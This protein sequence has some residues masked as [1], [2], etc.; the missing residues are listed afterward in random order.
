MCGINFV[1][2]QDVGN[3]S[4]CPPQRWALPHHVTSLPGMYEM[5]PKN[6]VLFI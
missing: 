2:L 3:K 5:G 4:D 1:L 6:D